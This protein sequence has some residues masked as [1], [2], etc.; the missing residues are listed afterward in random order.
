MP[1]LHQR[2]NGTHRLP[3]QREQRPHTDPPPVTPAPAGPLLLKSAE[4][5]RFLAIGERTLWQWTAD[6][7]IPCVKLPGG[8][9]VR[10]DVRDLIAFVDGHKQHGPCAAGG[11]GGTPAGG[12]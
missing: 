8:K 12:A 9:S 1:A 11:G 5:A 2:L 7:K 3:P 4:A 10:Y 6:G